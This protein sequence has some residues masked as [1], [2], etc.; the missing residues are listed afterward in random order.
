MKSSLRRFFGLFLGLVLTIGMMPGL[1]IQAYAASDPIAYLD[2]NGEVQTCTNYTVVTSSTTTFEDGGWYVV[3][4]ANLINNN[5]I[6]VEGS[7]HLI[8]ADN[9]TLNAND[10]INVLQGKTL[11]IY[12]QSIDNSAGSLIA[13]AATSGAAG[14]GGMQYGAEAANGGTIVINGGTIEAHAGPNAAGIGGGVK[15]TCEKVTINEGTVEARGWTPI[16]NEYGGAGIGGGGDG[17]AGCDVEINGGKVTAHCGG[18][19][20]ASAI[21]RGEVSDNEPLNGEIYF[22]D[23]IYVKAGPSESE[24]VEIRH[25]VSWAHLELWVQT[26]A[27]YPVWVGGVQIDRHNA[28]DVFSDGTVNYQPEKDGNAAILTLNNYH[29]EGEGREYTYGGDPYYGYA[30]IFSL[31]AL[32]ININGNNTVK[33]TVTEPFVGDGIHV[34]DGDL[35][36]KGDGALEVDGNNIGIAIY[37]R[38]GKISFDSGTVSSIGNNGMAIV[39]DKAYGESIFFNGGVVTAKGIL[40]AISGI[41]RAVV[42]DSMCVNA[43]D[44]APGIDVT[45]TFQDDHMQKWIQIAKPYPLWVGGTHVTIANNDN[46]LNDAGKTVRFSPAKKGSPA[47]LTLNG[48]HITTGF[49]ENEETIGIYYKGSDPLSLALQPGSDNK[50]DIADNGG[51]GIKSAADL[52][53]SGSG[54]LLVNVAKGTGIR[55]NELTINGGKT[56]VNAGG[57][58]ISSTSK[59]V[60]LVSGSLNISA[61]VGIE[62]ARNI[63]IG[64]KASVVATGSSYALGNI[65]K[66]EIVGLA[67]SDVKGSKGKATVAPNAAGQRVEKYKKVQFPSA[68]AKVLKTPSSKTLIYDGKAQ[69]LVS[70]GRATGGT[71]KYALGK[72]ARTVPTKGWSTTIPTRTAKGEYYIWYK[73]FGDSTHADSNAVCAKVKIVDKAILVSGT[74]RARMTAKDKTSLLFAWSK[75]KYVDGYD[76]FFSPCNHDDK[77]YKCKYVKTIKGNKTFSGIKTKLRQGAAYK[78]Y[79]KAFVLVGGKKKYVRTSPMVHAFAGGSSKNDTNAKTV[80]VNKT[81]IALTKGKSFSIKAKIVGQDKKKKVMSAFHVAPLRYMTSDPKV[82]TVNSAGKIF[83][84]G[85]GDCE[86]YVFAHNGVFKAINV[87]VK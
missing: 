66:N 87:T 20:L 3:N 68:I 50:V 54:K 4:D 23:N 13:T 5:R 77:V 71:L 72:D 64:K 43:G 15:G 2:E 52:T 78:A 46:V 10:G 24:A 18:G 60:S 61:K 8:L 80:V 42:S 11:T 74:L 17:G 79:V 65:V 84:R 26:E 85:K 1:S 53:V 19:R 56:T 57:T 76:I 16:G 67:W 58:G 27:K 81:K 51:Q 35:T 12:A 7:A 6:N 41:L 70:A 9:A 63:I 47:T 40:R 48:A 30:A 73:V 36:F 75:V 49:T 21:G 62:A 25:L 29:F 83:A 86:I 34:N 33:T 39:S 28:A 69:M 44:S 37:A 14:I 59:D 22:G 38:E 82:A 55:A 32:T 45:S 31:Q